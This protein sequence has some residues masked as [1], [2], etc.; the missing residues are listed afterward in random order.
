MHEQILDERKKEK[1]ANQS[2]YYSS[3]Q[4]ENKGGVIRKNI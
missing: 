3:N 4:D 1:I 2:S